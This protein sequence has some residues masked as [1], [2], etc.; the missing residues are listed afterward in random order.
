MKIFYQID[1]INQG[2]KINIKEPNASYGV[3]MYHEQNLK[4]NHWRDSKE[5]LTGLKKK[6]SHL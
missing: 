5:D 1:S 3:K 2:I 6:P 4:I